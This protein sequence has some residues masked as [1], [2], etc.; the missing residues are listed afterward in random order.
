MACFKP[1]VLSALALAVG[2]L[3][4]S[5]A[6]SSVR[7][8]PQGR[9]VD[10]VLIGFAVFQTN[11]SEDLEGFFDS[12]DQ[13]PAEFTNRQVLNLRLDG[14]ISENITVDARVAHD[15]ENLRDWRYRIEVRGVDNQLAVGELDGAFLDTALTRY[16]TPFYGVE[17]KATLGPLATQ[18]FATLRAGN[19]R[20][21]RLRGT[22]L[23]G[24][25]ILSASPVL[26]GSERVAL[27]VRDRRDEERIVRSDFKQ[28][29]RDY[30]IDY[31]TGTLLFDEPIEAETFDGDPVLVVIEYQ[32]EAR[33]GAQSEYLAGTR[34]QFAP[35][36]GV[37]LGSTYLRSSGDDTTSLGGRG[38]LGVDQTIE[39]G[40]HFRLHNEMAAPV[41]ELL[42][43]SAS[44]WRMEATAKPIP[45]LELKG[46]F[47][48]VGADFEAA[49]D[50]RLESQQD[51]AEWQLD[52]TFLPLEGHRLSGGIAVKSDDVADDP[53]VERTETR[54]VSFGYEARVEGWPLLRARF[55][56]R[57]TDGPGSFGSGDSNVVT[58]TVDGE[59]ELGVLPLLGATEVKAQ[60]RLERE[61]N[62]L[63][64]AREH[65]FRARLEA[66]PR[67]GLDGFLELRHAFGTD[68]AD[69]AA[70]PQVTE[71]LFGG[72]QTLARKLSASASLRVRSTG[73][74]ESRSSRRT[75]V[76]DLRWEPSKRLRTM[77]K[78]ERTLGRS[79]LAESRTQNVY[80]QA[81]LMPARGLTASLGYRLDDRLSKPTDVDGS[82]DGEYFVSLLVERWSGLKLFARAERGFSE[83]R[84]PPF[85]ATLSSRQ[86]WLGGVS[87]DITDRITALGELKDERLDGAVDAHRRALVFEL[88]RA[89]TRLMRIGVGVEVTVD[90]QG[91]SDRLDRQRVYLKLIGQL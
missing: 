61:Q 7:Y 68:T 41:G 39:L 56:R 29:G 33:N 73:S 66:H 14:T 46:R 42:D 11:L 78:Y 3:T 62:A 50:P 24:P 81:M 44:A 13:L 72:R 45:E 63:S 74:G 22:N 83:E 64:R 58:W 6:E 85:E 60:Y 91:E 8:K 18:S 87:W 38:V 54:T 1:G 59:D 34:V 86:T 80:A 10:L 88:S 20:V 32:F 28:R 23:S 31:F 67:D 49:A 35:V 27:E 21:D 84:L 4:S 55:E 43:R 57:S 65:S 47:R 37:E 69:A 16:D 53:E 82:F 48:R 17:A 2:L 71:V 36:K 70:S 77:L 9:Q 5:I 12:A 75:A 30:T 90:Q 40:E 51:R 15:R 79:D 26:E 19:Y 89:L 52:A 76:F 25:F